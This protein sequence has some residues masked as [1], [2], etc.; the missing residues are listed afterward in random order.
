MERKADVNGDLGIKVQMLNEEQMQTEIE[1]ML[2]LIANSI[3][4]IEEEVCDNMNRMIWK[5]NSLEHRQKQQNLHGVE[6][7]IT[8][9]A[10]ETED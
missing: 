5:Q 6:Q 4:K 10:H 8:T 7:S 2:Y 3:D 9:W 1:K